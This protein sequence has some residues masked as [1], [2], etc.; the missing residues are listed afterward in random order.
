MSPLLA[1]SPKDVPF[2]LVGTYCYNKKNDSYNK[3][4]SMIFFVALLVMVLV[5]VVYG[6]RNKDYAVG[7]AFGLALGYCIYAAALLSLP[8][9]T[10]TTTSHHKL[11][12]M[13]AGEGKEYYLIAN[14]P[15]GEVT[16]AV[17]ENGQTEAVTGKHDLGIIIQDGF[18]ELT[19]E[20]KE[21]HNYWV[22]P[23]VIS[24]YTKHEFHIPEGSYKPL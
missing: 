22:Q 17:Q 11:H 24:S 5:P 19:I 4:S 1:Y 23:W 16:Y 6:Y 13:D 12:A 3:R 10:T 20:V 15:T 14:E 8:R 2:G 9:E 18:K 7:V 21:S